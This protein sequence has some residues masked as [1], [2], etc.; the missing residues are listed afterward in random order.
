[1]DSSAFEL[2]NFVS[3]HGSITGKQNYSLR[4]Q[5]FR[6]GTY[7]YKV[8]QIDKDGSYIWSAI[9]SV[10]K[11]FPA[12][13]VLYP[14]PTHD[15]V[16]IQGIEQTDNL[17][18]T[19]ASGKVIFDFEIDNSGNNRLATNEWPKGIYFVRYSLGNTLVHEKL[20]ID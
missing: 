9:E 16:I 15:F 3:A 14:N 2:I 17:Q 11:I 7:Y 20:V 6:S 19:D 5:I 13:V 1:M 12:A 18:I 10:Q 4:D 8:K